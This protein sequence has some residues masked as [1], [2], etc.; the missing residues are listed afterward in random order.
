MTKQ[1]Q[2]RSK[3]SLILLNQIVKQALKETIEEEEEEENQSDLKK[4]KI[5]PEEGNKN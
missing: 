2:K 5:L 3:E 1:K 4:T